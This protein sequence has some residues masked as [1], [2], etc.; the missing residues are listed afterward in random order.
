MRSVGLTLPWLAWG[1]DRNL[2]QIRL[3]STIGPT[4][5]L[6]PVAGRPVLVP[7][8]RVGDRALVIFVGPQEMTAMIHAGC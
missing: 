2:G 5:P 1:A 4:G 3:V 8:G 6:G 7:M